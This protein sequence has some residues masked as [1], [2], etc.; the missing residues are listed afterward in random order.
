MNKRVKKLW[1][2]AL[3]SGKFKQA[4]HTLREGRKNQFCC[5]G[6]LCEVHNQTVGGQWK[7]NGDYFDTA[8]VLPEEVME[9]AKLKNDNP[10]VPYGKRNETL[11]GLNDSGKDFNF[12]ADRIEKYL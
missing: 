5:L 2:K 12:I 11:A 10:V 1:L 6:I 4:Q 7:A 8:G 9:W 3:R